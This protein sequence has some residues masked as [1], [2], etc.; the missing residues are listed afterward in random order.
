MAS[1]V[2]RSVMQ[3]A[4]PSSYSLE[5]LHNYVPIFL[6]L[7]RMRHLTQQLTIIIPFVST[8]LGRDRGG[9]SFDCRFHW[10]L[11]P[12]VHRGEQSTPAICYW[13]SCLSMPTKHQ[14]ILESREAG[15]RAPFHD[16]GNTCFDLVMAREN[17]NIS[18]A[19]CRKNIRQLSE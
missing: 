16:G 17:D 10:S 15:N 11:I 6:D 14:L 4:F 18:I 3:A 5:D 19:S 1:Q 7:V 13:H 2:I 9:R 12:Q 8:S